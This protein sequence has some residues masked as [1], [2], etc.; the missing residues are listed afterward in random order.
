MK[1][2]TLLQGIPAVALLS[3]AAWAATRSENRDGDA[4]DG[5]SSVYELR[6]YHAAAGKLPELL[7]RFRDHTIQIFNRRRMIQRSTRR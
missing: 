7:A 1:R 2:R 3:P 6:V 5:A 4:P